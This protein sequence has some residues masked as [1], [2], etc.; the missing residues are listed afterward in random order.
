MFAGRPLPSARAP[1]GVPVHM[2]S[3]YDRAGSSRFVALALALIVASGCGGGSDAEA[4]ERQQ[5][6]VTG[7][8]TVAPL[9]QELAIRF[10]AARTG[11]R[12][13]V[14]TGG[15]SR[16]ITDASLGR[17]DVGMSSRGLVEDEAEAL[18]EHLLAWDGVGFVVHASNA[19]PELGLD[20]LRGIFTGAIRDWSEV[21]GPPGEIVVVDRADGRSELALVKTHLGVSATAL[22]A[23]VIAGENSQVV[24][25]VVAN[26]LAISYLSIGTSEVEIARG[27]ALRLLALDGVE[28][29]SSAVRDGRYPLAR[30]LVLLTSAETGALGHAFVDFA[31]DAA[32]ADLVEDAAF[33]PVV[34]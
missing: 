17:A 20:E 27:A 26:P 4:A 9:V 13:D 29:S 28:A 12:V 34:E 22:R 18:T 15:S 19:V 30:P 5:L 24:K 33:V 31:L 21:G 7:S 16:G 25:T 14:Q 32:H 8:S 3:S 23:D 1:T 11:V 2:Q 10:E 6:M